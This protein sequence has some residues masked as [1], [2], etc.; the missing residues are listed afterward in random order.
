VQDER[1]I[2]RRLKSIVRQFLETAP[3]E[4]PGIV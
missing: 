2:A 4:P 1:Q 3:D